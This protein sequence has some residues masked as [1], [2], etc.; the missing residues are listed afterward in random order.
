MDIA[1]FYIVSIILGL[2]PE[3][4]FFTLFITYTKDIKEKRVKLFLLTCIIYFLC[5]LIQMY[6][7]VHYISFIV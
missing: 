7:L 5:M 4:L 3:V 6:K 2:V 1:L